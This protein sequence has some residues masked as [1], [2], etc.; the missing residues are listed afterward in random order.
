MELFDETQV[1]IFN[2]DTKEILMRGPSN[3]LTGLY[4]LDL[5]QNKK[6]P[7]IMIELDI[8]DT[9]FDNHVYE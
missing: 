8:P 9:Y 5:E 4:M 3:K 6:Q 1:V 7:N 2:K